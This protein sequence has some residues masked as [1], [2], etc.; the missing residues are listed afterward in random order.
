MSLGRLT[1][2]AVDLVLLSTVLAGV[3]RGT[4]FS[5]VAR[6]LMAWRPV[7]TSE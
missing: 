6:D 2:Y 1:H 4:G 3:K 5:Y 7:L